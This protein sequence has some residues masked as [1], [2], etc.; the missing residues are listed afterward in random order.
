MKRWVEWERD[1]RWK[2]GTQSRDSA[3]DVLVRSDSFKRSESNRM[4]AVS[5]SEHSIV[6]QDPSR[7]SPAG[8]SASHL[9]P[10]ES[11]HSSR[12]ADSLPLLEL[13]APLSAARSGVPSPASTSAPTNGNRTPSPY[14]PASVHPSGS[15]D[16]FGSTSDLPP[17]PVHQQPPQQTSQ[18]TVVGTSPSEFGASSYYP[19][20]GDEYDDAAAAERDPILSGQY[21]PESTFTRES[22]GRNP[23]VRSSAQAQYG[24]V[25]AEPDEMPPSPP[26]PAR[27]RDASF[28][29]SSVAS[30]YRGVS[31]VDDGPVADPTGGQ[32]RTV[33][34]SRRV[35]QTAEQT[36]RS[37]TF[38][39]NQSVD[40]S[41]H[42][43][44]VDTRSANNSPS[45]RDSSPSSSFYSPVVNQGGS[46]PPGAQGGLPPGARRRD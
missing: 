31:L 38:E 13:P 43:L 9:L 12:R 32:F 21:S 6:P 41:G 24:Q 17:L 34:R 4:S 16:S 25:V 44:S 19:S 40:S 11:G 35:S 23:F 37:R 29:R 45:M 46:R 8:G 36:R 33:Q 26:Q 39:R 7:V 28:A 3:F 22:R 18:H 20:A 10:S 14:L 1:R 15:G 27:S 5:S 2:A 30:R 42:A